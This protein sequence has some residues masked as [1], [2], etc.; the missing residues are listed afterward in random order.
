MQFA[1]RTVIVTGGGSGIGQAMAVRFAAERAAVVIADRNGGRA[2]EVVRKITAAG[3]KAV[4]TQTDVSLSHDVDAMMGLAAKSFGPID[5][6]VNNAAAPGGDNLA[7]MDETTWD[8]DLAVCLK[9][10]FLCCRGVLPGMI[11]RKRGVI[12]NIASVNGLGYFGN[13]AYSAAKAGIINLT[14]SL[15]ARYGRYGIRANA[16]APASIRTPIWQHRIEKDP[17]VLK[18]LEKWY[19]LGRIGEPEDVANAALFLASDAASWISGVVLRVDG[20][21]MAGNP[22]MAQDLLVESRDQTI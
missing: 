6:L 4:A 22:L 1:D 18:R 8:R 10:A 13:E 7:L 20:G 16:I 17:E 12:V 9:S 19:P 14:E 5:V 2:M 21:L 15:A 11:E 3:G